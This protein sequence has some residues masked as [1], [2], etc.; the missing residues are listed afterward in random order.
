M[1]GMGAKRNKHP[2]M[3]AVPGSAPIQDEL[4][5]KVD[6]RPCQEKAKRAVS[7]RVR[8]G[9]RERAFEGVEV[10]EVGNVVN[11]AASA[12]AR[13]WRPQAVVDVLSIEEAPLRLLVPAYHAVRSE[14]PGRGSDDY[15]RE[16][17]LRPALAQVRIHI[18]ACQPLAKTIK[19]VQSLRGAALL[20]QKG[21][22]AGPT[23]GPR[24]RTCF[25]PIISGPAVSNSAAVRPS[26][27]N[28][29][30]SALITARAL[31]ALAGSTD[32]LMTR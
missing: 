3:P 20:A 17:R 12:E 13:G 15:S 16:R 24:R 19:H 18:L 9:E 26:C 11:R 21:S 5:R 14:A 22:V 32:E 25:D 8:L 2:V 10:L 30:Y 27:R 1:A 4:C 23:R 7:V 28:R 6:P 31:K 29:S